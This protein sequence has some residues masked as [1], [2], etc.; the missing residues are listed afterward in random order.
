MERL[1]ERRSAA[2][3]G[4]VARLAGIVSMG[5]AAA[6]ILVLLAY[7]ASEVAAD[8]SLSLEDGYWIGRLPWTPI[9]VGLIVGGSTLAVVA[10]VAAVLVAGGN[11]RR[12]V[13]LVVAL[14]VIAWW[15]IASIPSI[16]VSGAWCGQPTCS[17]PSF[18]VI[19]VA[20]SVP[21]LAVRLLLIPAAIV[22][23][24]A[25]TARPAARRMVAA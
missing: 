21:D 25:V 9:G 12:L 13:A 22:T 19:T 6:G 15:A 3:I 8:P 1:D 7:A 17:P 10:G 20:Y 23:L 16:G 4:H 2:S 14:P 18:D 24:L 5:L 11:I